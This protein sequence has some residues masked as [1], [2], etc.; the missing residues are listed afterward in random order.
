MTTATSH[1]PNSA[2]CAAALPAE[3]HPSGS[4]SAD[5]ERRR[6]D[7]EQQRLF[8]EAVLR[9]QLELDAHYAARLQEVE[10]ADNERRRNMEA[11]LRQDAQRLAA[12]VAQAE[13]TA[14]QQ[15]SEHQ[16]NARTAVA[17]KVHELLT[18]EKELTEQQRRLE[19]ADSLRQRQFDELTKRM[20]NEMKERMSTLQRRYDEATSTQDAQ[21]QHDDVERQRRDEEKKR[22][23]EERRK[24]DD[25]DRAAFFSQYHASC[26]PPAAPSFYTPPHHIPSFHSLG[27]P[28][29]SPSS[30]FA[31]LDKERE[32]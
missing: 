21:R 10:R 2:A 32:R 14:E 5:D 28:P 16:V 7:Q 24:R 20:E 3:N 19:E 30:A 13:V 22:D 29:L 8:D 6:R 23:D 9:R 12:A 15:F 31:G 18:K 27:T 26:S 11:S 4:P 1:L 25:H 17:R